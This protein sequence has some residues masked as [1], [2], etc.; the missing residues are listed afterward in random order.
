M[1][2]AIWEVKTMEDAKENEKAKKKRELREAESSRD[3]SALV[4]SD[5][6]SLFPKPLE[7]VH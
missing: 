5:S 3:R 6:A 2:I 1:F 4:R 7:P